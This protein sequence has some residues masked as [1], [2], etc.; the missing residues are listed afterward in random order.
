MSDSDEWYLYY[1]N[2]KENF[3]WGELMYIEPTHGSTDHAFRAKVRDPVGM[4]SGDT[5][6][7]AAISFAHSLQKTAQE[8]LTRVANG[9]LRQ[10]RPR[11]QV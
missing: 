6:A 9:E 11:Q 5:P 4:G 3:R 2:P 10:A 1:G 8:I 7:E